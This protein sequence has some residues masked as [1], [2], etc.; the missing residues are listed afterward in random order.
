MDTLSSFIA[1][2]PSTGRTSLPAEA[3]T[4][5]WMEQLRRTRWEIEK[6]EQDPEL[7][8]RARY[9]FY[10]DPQTLR[11]RHADSPGLHQLLEIVESRGPAVDVVLSQPLGAR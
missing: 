7:V 5:E 10:A 1:G 2:R 3:T 8:A 9:A 11:R 4:A 6:R